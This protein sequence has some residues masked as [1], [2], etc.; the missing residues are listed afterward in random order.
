MYIVHPYSV[1][2]CTITNNHAVPVVTLYHTKGTVLYLWL[3]VHVHCV[4]Y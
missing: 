2:Y 4:L 1:L 3:H